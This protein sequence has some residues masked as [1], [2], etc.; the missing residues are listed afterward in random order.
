MGHCVATRC[1]ATE[2]DGLILRSPV[3]SLRIPPDG[4]IGRGRNG[5]MRSESGPMGWADRVM[6]ISAG[7]GVDRLRGDQ[8]WLA[9][10]SGEWA[11]AARRA[12]MPAATRS[13]QRPRTD[14]SLYPSSRNSATQA[15]LPLPSRPQCGLKRPYPGFGQQEDTTP[16]QSIGA[17]N[18]EYMAQATHLTHQRHPTPSPQFPRTAEGGEEPLWGSDFTL[19]AGVSGARI[20]GIIGNSFSPSRD[21]SSEAGAVICGGWVRD[22]LLFWCFFG[23]FEAIVVFSAARC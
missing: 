18:R 17:G 1:R 23:I 14:Q 12:S 8:D 5:D 13:Q 7:D 2:L 11:S 9:V 21:Q 16:M 20:S 6:R 15:L 22:L 4:D 3:A 19:T 10:A